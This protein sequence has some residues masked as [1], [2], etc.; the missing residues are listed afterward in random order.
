MQRI[1]AIMWAA[2]KLWMFVDAIRRK[3]SERWFWLI[4]F[5]PG[6]GL[7]YFAMVKMRDRSMQVL[8]RRMLQSLKT[9]PSVDELQS[10][11]DRTPSTANRIRLGQGLY[12]AERYE[13]ALEHFE[14]VLAHRPD[15]KHGLYGVGLALL[16]IARRDNGK[17]EGAIEPLSRLI[18]LHRGYRD[19][20][21][22]PDLAE[23]LWRCGD[24]D[25][26]H[27]LLDELVSTA[28]RLA[29]QVLRAEFLQKAGQRDAAA[30][31]LREAL[32]EE[33]HQPSHVRR[34]NRDWERR[35]KTLLREMAA[36]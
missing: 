28:P 31:S 2:F 24:K 5:V 22:W 32:E 17:P 1:L 18:E 35:A 29:H 33:R 7:A 34:L 14:K 12:D 3:A 4:I 9:P 10:Q 11:Y 19:Y 8:G 16:A 36:A 21:A 23:V 6:G 13:G 25:G 15:D 30:R 26:C 20:A 27:Q